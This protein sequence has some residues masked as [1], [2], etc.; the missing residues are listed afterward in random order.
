MLKL[1]TNKRE[2]HFI[3]FCLLYPKSR[4]MNRLWNRLFLLMAGVMVF[5]IGAVAQPKTSLPAKPNIIYIYADDLGYG[6]LGSYG[7]QIIKTPNLDLL[8]RQG[9]RFTQHYAGAPVCAPSRAMLLTGKHSGQSYIRGNYELGGFE[10]SLEAGQMPLPEG[11]QTLPRLLKKAGYTT[12]ICG[13]WGLGG[14][15]TS[16]HPLK[17]GFDYFYGYLDQKQAHSFYPSH[18]WENERWDTLNNGYIYPHQTLDSGRK[19]KA[20]FLPFIGKDYSQEKITEKAQAFI[21]K[22]KSK[23]FFL[24]LAYT[25]PHVSLQVPEKFAQPYIGKIPGD[26]PYYGRRGYLPN[27]HPLATYAGMISALDHYVGEIMAQV[28]ALGIDNNTIIMFSSDNG[29]S[30]HGG[31]R[32]EVFNSNGGF[33]GLKGSL[34]EGG[35]RVPFI[36]RWPGKI[37]P[38]QV[39]DHISAQFDLLPTVAE[40]L[41][42]KPEYPVNGISLL[43]SLL[44]RSKQP[45][46]PYLYFEFPEYGGQQAVLQGDWKG[47]RRNLISNPHAA[48]ELYNLSI[49]R[50]E[51]NDVADEHPEIIE[52]F[53]GIA[54]E[55]HQHPQINEWE[56]IDGKSRK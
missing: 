46:H 20:D 55:S 51:E 11:I 50:R 45:Q 5:T 13:K 32:P 9:I 8:A 52:R 30:D 56:V 15:G 41:N 25:I 54:Q 12:A 43:P 6:E 17:Q 44:G 10:D 31:A 48:W 26:E 21:Q 14:P 1:S 39:N 18:L 53:K 22:N 16:G 28:K 37:K 7:Q 36:A 34:Y 33:R 38:N 47:I 49:D 35:I 3:D 29:P 19:E 2:K 40:L 42:I 23:P 4:D 27:F 24:Y